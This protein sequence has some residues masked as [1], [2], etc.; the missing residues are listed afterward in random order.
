MSLKAVIYL[1]LDIAVGRE[2]ACSITVQTCW[3]LLPIFCQYLHWFLN[4]IF[5]IYK[6]CSNLWMAVQI[7]SIQPLSHNPQG[8][9]HQKC[10]L[11]SH[12]AVK[13]KFHWTSLGSVEGFKNTEAWDTS[14]SQTHSL[15]SDISNDNITFTSI[16]I[17]CG[18]KWMPFK[19]IDSFL[20]AALVEDNAC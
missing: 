4:F 6:M 17:P 2:A 5:N 20:S 18:S 16:I 1:C 9:Q 15:L 12:E 13:F 8:E 11:P 7:W 3:L 14:P 19:L 10:S